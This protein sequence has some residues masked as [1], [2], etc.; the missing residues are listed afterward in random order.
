M[1]FGVIDIVF[2][3]VILLLLIRAL[4]RG[5]IKEVFSMA[6][7][8]LGLTL[9]FFFH[10]RLAAILAEKYFPGQTVIPSVA[11]FAGIFIVVFIVILILEKILR[12]I[13][14]GVRLGGIDHFLGALFGIAEGILVVSLFL[15]LFSAQPLMDP[16]PVLNGSV[17]YRMLRPVIGVMEETVIALPPGDAGV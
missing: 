15:W 14:D 7:W 9:A 11:A 17:F 2:G 8:V 12:D 13:V 1:R 3:V 10:R 6:Q 4:V 5:F 16:A